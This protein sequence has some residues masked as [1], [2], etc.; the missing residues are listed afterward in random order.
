MVGWVLAEERGIGGSELLGENVGE[1]YG[2][3]SNM[4]C[5]ERNFVLVLRLRSVA[6]AG[7]IRMGI[8]FSATD[9]PASPHS[10][11]SEVTSMSKPDYSLLPRSI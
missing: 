4:E 5:R 9:P 11:R 3:Q 6:A 8:A 1:I 2:N 7:L 10:H